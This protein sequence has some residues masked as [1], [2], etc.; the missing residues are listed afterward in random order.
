MEYYWPIV[1]KSILFLVF[2]LISNTACIKKWPTFSNHQ[3]KPWVLEKLRLP[4][5]GCINE[6]WMQMAY[7]TRMNSLSKPLAQICTHNTDVQRLFSEGFCFVCRLKCDQIPPTFR[8]LAWSSCTGERRR[9][10]KQASN[11][12]ITWVRQICLYLLYPL[13]EPTLF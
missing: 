6:K 12:F 2:K 1:G 11:L 5:R 3:L 10:K 8:N 4:V 13:Q 9:S 7:L